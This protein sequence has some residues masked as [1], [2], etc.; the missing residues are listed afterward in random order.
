MKELSKVIEDEGALY[1]VVETVN[2]CEL[3]ATG[4]RGIVAS[5]ARPIECQIAEYTTLPDK[6]RKRKFVLMDG[7]A[8]IL[9]WKG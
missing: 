9:N 6:I 5:T 3:T 4:W 8:I 1:H 7:C 2:D